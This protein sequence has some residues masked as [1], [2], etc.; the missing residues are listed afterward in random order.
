V[1]TSSTAFNASAQHNSTPFNV[2]HCRKK[3]RPHKWLIFGLVQAISGIFSHD[4]YPASDGEPGCL[5]K[6]CGVR[7][8]PPVKTPQ[9]CAGEVTHG[10]PVRVALPTDLMTDALLLASARDG[11]N[12]RHSRR[13]A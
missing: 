13:H 3:L 4:T 2:S 7:Q 12:K 5:E 9:G 1:L 11:R 8:T 10:R 6:I